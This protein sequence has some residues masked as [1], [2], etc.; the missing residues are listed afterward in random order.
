MRKPLIYFSMIVIAIIVYLFHKE[1]YLNL[2][3]LQSELNSLINFK[4]NHPIQFLLVFETIFLFLT[5]FSIPGSIVL[6][7]LAGVV[8]GKI[9]GSILVTINCA[10]GATIAF[11]MARFFLRSSLRKRFNIQL[12]KIEKLMKKNGLWYLWMLR[13]LPGS[14]YVLIN[15]LMGLTNIKLFPFFFV[16]FIGMLPGNFIFVYAG[17]RVLEVRSAL[18]ILNPQLILILILF[19]V[20]PFFFR[21]LRNF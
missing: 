12:T 6:T 9:W 4:E 3:F 5:S 19:A 17:H 21:Q 7:L 10:S 13:M 11:L 1:K 20:I 14:P 2:A 15:M 18:E 8:Y 16:S